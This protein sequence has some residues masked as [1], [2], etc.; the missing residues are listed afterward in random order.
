MIIGCYL[1]PELPEIPN[2]TWISTKHIFFGHAL[3]EM[4]E[5]FREPEATPMP[6]LFAAEEMSQRCL[7]VRCRCAMFRG[8]TRFK[9]R[10]SCKSEAKQR[11]CMEL[12]TMMKGFLQG[13]R[14]LKVAKTRKTFLFLSFPLKLC[15]KSHQM[16]GKA[17]KAK[18][19][20]WERV[21]KMS[22][23]RIL[24]RRSSMDQHGRRDRPCFPGEESQN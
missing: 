8:L 12:W 20:R 17:Y 19:E 21:D 10:R 11:N 18:W 15:R 9:D 22:I 1:A 13:V 2:S 3:F 24:R 16:S 23:L 6:E 5:S 14:D 4:S 7:Q